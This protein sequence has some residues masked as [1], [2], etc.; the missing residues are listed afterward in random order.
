MLKPRSQG[1]FLRIKRVQ[2]EKDFAALSAQ[3]ERLADPL[4]QAKT[5]VQSRGW[6]VF[7]DERG[8]WFIGTKPQQSD[9]DLIAFAKRHGWTPKPRD[10]KEVAAK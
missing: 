4:E 6:K 3:L 2:R 7:P 1:R 10:E 8:G 5:F 9:K